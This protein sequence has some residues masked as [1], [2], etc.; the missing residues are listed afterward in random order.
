[1]SQCVQ[2]GEEGAGQFGVRGDNVLC[3]GGNGEE[4]REVLYVGQIY[5]QE[6]FC[7]EGWT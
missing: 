6:M 7:F 3:R 4:V 1:M 2:P 5:I